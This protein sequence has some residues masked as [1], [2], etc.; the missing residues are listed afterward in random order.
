VK[1]LSSA[2]NDPPTKGLGG[3]GSWAIHH[4]TGIL[5]ASKPFCDINLKS[6]SVMYEFQWSCKANKVQQEDNFQI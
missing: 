3:F 6:S 1:A 5:T 4:P 2:A